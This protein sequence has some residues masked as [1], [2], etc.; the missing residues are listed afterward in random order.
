MNHIYNPTMNKIMG[1]TTINQY[2]IQLIFDVSLDIQ[3]LWA[4]ICE[5]A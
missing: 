4:E 5:S 1:S 2:H 3:C